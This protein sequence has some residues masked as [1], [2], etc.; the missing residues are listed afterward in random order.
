MR[1]ILHT[2]IKS[3]KDD[4]Q[5]KI[6]IQIKPSVHSTK[7]AIGNN[8]KHRMWQMSSDTAIPKN[9]PPLHID[10]LTSKGT[11]DMEINLENVIMIN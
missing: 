1:H 2:Y 11:K 8:G 6:F 3:W 9:W 4:L 7:I 5:L 10:N